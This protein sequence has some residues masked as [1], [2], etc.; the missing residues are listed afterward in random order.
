MSGK[1]IN[2]VVTGSWG[3]REINNVTDY[4]VDADG[5]LMVEGTSPSHSSPSH[6]S[7]YKYVFRNWDFILVKIITK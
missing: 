5:F 1:T 7:D 4:K 6:S 3:L 2:M